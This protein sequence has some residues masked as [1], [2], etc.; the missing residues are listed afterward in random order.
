M[1]AVAG[2]ARPRGLKK[3]GHVLSLLCVPSLFLASSQGRQP[4]QETAAYSGT[5]ASPC[6]HEGMPGLFFDKVLRTQ[7][8]RQTHACVAGMPGL[9]YYGVY[10][11]G[12]FIRG[13]LLSGAQVSPCIP[14][15]HAR[16]IL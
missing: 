8:P 16:I 13:A 5:Q 4:P 11:G 14:G 6:M 7:V 1:T 2:C 12:W 9:V 10:Y 15:R 3:K